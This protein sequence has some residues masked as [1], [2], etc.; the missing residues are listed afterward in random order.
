MGRIAQHGAF[1]LCQSRR[2]QHFDACRL[3]LL[4]ALAALGQA[5]RHDAP[6]ML[7]Q[8][9]QGADE[10]ALGAANPEGLGDDQE[11]AFRQVSA[12]RHSGSHI[13][14]VGEPMWEAQA[15]VNRP[16]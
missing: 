8:P 16:T 11:A 3:H 2:C 6:T 10:M 1:A 12:L 14:S 4:G 13:S 9:R 7:N 5:K 15:C